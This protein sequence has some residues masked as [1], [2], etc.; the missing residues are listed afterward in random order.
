MIPLG[1]RIDGLAGLA[2]QYKRL[3]HDLI[4]DLSAE[5]ETLS[6]AAGRDARDQGWRHDRL[7]VVRGGAL[8]AC[9]Q[10]RRLLLW[11]EGDVILPDPED[12]LTYQTDGAVLLGG[13]HYPAVLDE[14]LGDPARARRWSELL[15]TRQALFARLLAARIPE[16]AH[17]RSRFAYFHPGDDLVRQG[18]P[19]DG[20]YNLFEGEAEVL[21]DGVAVGRV[22]AGEVLGAIAMLT[23]APRG[24]TVR[25]LGRCAAVKV[26]AD[27]FQSLIRS[28]PSMILGLMTDMARQITDLNGQ[29][30][31][32][33]H[34]ENPE[35][36]PGTGSL[37]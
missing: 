27:Q 12:G 19:A 33:S 31:S 25:A 1:E 10:G 34:G 18:E 30:V 21:V 5:A 2:R 7:Y 32:L 15:V 20:V 24:A 23:G 4:H 22:G 29:V 6:L 3:G 14:L 28:N 8:M 13:Y 17:A 11:D 37:A 36:R 16:D 26:P 9:Y 35:R